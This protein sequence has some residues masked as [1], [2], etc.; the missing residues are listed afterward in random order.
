MTVWQSKIP[1]YEQTI[2]KI[3]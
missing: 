2:M 1:I 3:K